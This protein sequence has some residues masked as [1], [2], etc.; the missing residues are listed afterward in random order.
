MKNI[1]LAVALAIP[2][3]ANANII[4][5]GSFESTNQT[6]ATSSTYA[7]VTGWTSTSG[8]NISHNFAGSA[9]DGFNFAKLDTGTSNSTMQQVVATVV[10]EVYALSFA[11]SPQI[12]QSLD[13]NGISAYWNGVLL[14]ELASQGGTSSL[15]STSQFSVTGTGQ[16]LLSFQATGTVDGAGGF[17]D[18]VAL[19]GAAP[20]PPA[21][22][23]SVPAPAPSV[24]AP[25]PSVPAPPPVVIIPLPPASGAAN[26]PPS[27]IPSAVP[28]PGAVWL[29]G[30]A[31]GLVGLRRKKS[32]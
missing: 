10:G 7:G 19:N 29:F 21:P 18:N 24:P 22:A 28:V 3:F 20:V 31:L 14:V 11:Y 1:A 5:N 30:S 16:D 27:S 9:S 12:D 4:I 8:I 15:W 2:A 25:A 13:T 32:I 26:P 17:V 23:P 6:N